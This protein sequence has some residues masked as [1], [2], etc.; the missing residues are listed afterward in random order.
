MQQLRKYALAADCSHIMVM[1]ERVGIYLEFVDASDDNEEIN[2]L[3]S[4]HPE[5]ITPENEFITPDRFTLRQLLA[6][7]CYRAFGKVFP[8]RPIPTESEATVTVGSGPYSGSLPPDIGPCNS[9][10]THKNAPTRQQPSRSAKSTRVEQTDDPDAPFT[11][12]VPG[13]SVTLRLRTETTVAAPA[14]SAT[15][16]TTRTHAVSRPDSGF[17]EPVSPP[18]R[19]HDAPARPFS[20][21]GGSSARFTITRVFTRAAALLTATAG[22]CYIAKLFSPLHT[23]I[24]HLLLQ[25]EV[26]AYAAAKPLQGRDIPHFYGTWDIPG[27]THLGVLLLE[28]IAPGTTIAAL[29]HAGEYQRVRGLRGSAER[30]LQALHG[31]GVRHGDLVARNMMVASCEGVGERVV[32][33]D[34]DCAKVEGLE[35]LK[36]HWADWVFFKEAFKVPEEETE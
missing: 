17:H 36:R 27:A 25:N 15:A 32:V 7:M 28:Y 29:K 4:V 33:V 8:L 16:P 1:D 6:F 26:A 19:K 10:R 14:S 2:F 9:K 21:P 35:G 11:A 12:W 34:F 20:S 22:K 30:A 31:R 3:L 23:R 5:I 18:N 24:A 13:S